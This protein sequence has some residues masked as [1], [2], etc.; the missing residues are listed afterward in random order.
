MKGRGTEK[1]TGTVGNGSVA[2]KR[3]DK[4]ECNCVRER[5]RWDKRLREGKRQELKRKET[6]NN[7]G[8]GVNEGMA[9][10]GVQQKRKKKNPPKDLKRVKQGRTVAQ[11]GEAKKL[12]DRRTTRVGVAK[13]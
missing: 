11:R 5:G 4:K 12:N 10:R 3:G 8:A 9:E 13:H 1:E 7:A 6:W 2:G